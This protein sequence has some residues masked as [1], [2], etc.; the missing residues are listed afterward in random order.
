MAAFAT[1]DDVAAR[2]PVT[3]TDAQL[4][5]ATALLGDVAEQIRVYAP[6]LPEDSGLGKAISCQVVL[7]ALFTA[8]GVRTKTVGQVS[9]TYAGDGAGGVWL[10][11]DEIRDLLGSKRPKAFTIAPYVP[12]DDE[13]EPELI[14]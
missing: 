3:L 7:R 14:A 6:R 9:E 1:A 4:A 13:G 8:A 12:P 10:T 11:A 2:S 5:R